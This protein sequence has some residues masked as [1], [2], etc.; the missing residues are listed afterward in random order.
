MRQ[1][2]LRAPRTLDLVDL[3]TPEPRAG[4]VVVRILAALTCGT[5]LK[6]Y[7]RGHARLRFGPFGHE[8]AGEI[9]ALGDGV[10]GF[11]AGQPVVFTPT[12]ACG[13]C[14]PCRRGKDNLCTTLFDEMAIGAYGDMMRV[15]ARIVRRHLFPKPPGLSYVEAAFLEPL[16]CVVHA[17]RRLGGVNGDRVAVIGVGA[18]GLL[19][20]QEATRRGLEVIAVGRRPDGLGLAARLGA[21]HVVN[22]RE[23]EPGEALRAL[24][25]EGPEIVV[26]CTGSEDVW[27]AA[28]A[29]AA[30]GGSVLLFGGLAAGSQPQFDAT[31]LHYAEV[32]LVSAFH[33]RTADVRDAL[34]LLASGAIRPAALITGLRPL[35]DIKAVFD[36][37]DRGAGIKYAILP[38][39]GT[40]R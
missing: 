9:A 30:P 37:L 6:T 17:W 2:I 29:W 23:T 13:E 4:E 32:D 20:V 40:W 36:E 1:A 24:T 5:D 16:A 27:Q 39:G 11:A 10:G 22:I 38:D 12:A 14:G 21:R 26:E 34:T 25:G 7:R 8:A 19:H 15:P 18:I 3:P 31:R 33:Y 35:D 28:P